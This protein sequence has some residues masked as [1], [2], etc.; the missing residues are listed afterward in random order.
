MA[1]PPPSKSVAKFEELLEWML[2][3]GADRRSVVIAVDVSKSMLA[4]DVRPNRL[5]RQRLFIRRLLR[6][7]GQGRKQSE[8]QRQ[9]E[10]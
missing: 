3:Q 10:K 2:A 6:G 1:S 5:E 4:E 7:R 8:A 9:T